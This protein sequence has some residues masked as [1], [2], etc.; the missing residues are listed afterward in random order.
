MPKKKKK[1]V[2][3][4][5]DEWF[6]VNPLVLVRGKHFHCQPH[7][8][9]VMVRNAAEARGFWVRVFINEGTLTITDRSE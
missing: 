8:M 1:P 5:W 3:Y 6:E 2:R 9:S 7:S 4:P